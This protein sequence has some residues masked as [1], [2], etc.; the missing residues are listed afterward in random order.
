M[1]EKPTS[2]SL[3]DMILKINLMISEAIS[4]IGSGKKICS[5][6]MIFPMEHISNGE[7]ESLKNFQISQEEELVADNHR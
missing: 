6:N 1:S 5:K 2:G 3:K 7:I 4:L